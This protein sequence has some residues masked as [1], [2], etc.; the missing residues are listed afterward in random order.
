MQAVI[1]LKRRR[2]GIGPAEAGRRT[3]TVLRMPGVE[4]AEAVAGA[5]RLAGELVPEA[6]EVDAL[7]VRA[8]GPDHHRRMVGRGRGCR[9]K[10]TG[11][12]PDSRPLHRRCMSPAQVASPAS[13]RST[14]GAMRARSPPRPPGRAGPWRAV[15]RRGGS[16]PSRHCIGSRARAPRQRTSGSGRRASARPP[17]AARRPIPRTGSSS[18]EALHHR[19]GAAAAG[20]RAVGAAAQPGL[21]P[22]GAARRPLKARP[23]RPR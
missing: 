7:G 6:V 19:T 11:S 2:R 20:G 17:S 15:G 16:A 3:G 14:S 8:S 21:V 22:G 18:N 10:C 12:P 5:G 23:G 9:R 4:P 13:A 1:G